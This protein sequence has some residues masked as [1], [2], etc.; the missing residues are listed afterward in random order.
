MSAGNVTLRASER[1]A[2]SDVA[3]VAE[4]A[5]GPDC[6]SAEER[7]LP[8]SASPPLGVICPQQVQS[9]AGVQLQLF[10][11]LEEVARTWKA[12][13][14]HADRTV[15]QSF[16]WLA[17][18]QRHIGA[19]RGC[20]PAIV[21]GRDGDG[22]P[23]FILQ[24]A[25]EPSGAARRLTWLGSE[26]CDYNAPLLAEQFSDRMS[27]QRF[28]RAWRDAIALLQADAR[29]RFDLIDLQKM[30]ETIGAQRNPFLDLGVQPHPSGAYLANLGKDWEA[31]YAAKRS[32]ATRKRER[33]QL[34]QLAGHGAVRFVDVEA[35]EEAARTLATLF[36]QKSRA[37][38]R[39]GV[40]D[41]FAGPGRRDF[42]SAIAAD[43][44][45]REL[46][47][48]SRLDVGASMAAINIG[49][50]F[51]GCYYLILS[52]YD[53]GEVARFGPGR[54]HLNE[55]LRHAIARGF[56]RF[57][58]TVGDEPYKRDWSDIELALF[59]HLAAISLRGYTV[60]TMTRAFRRAKR[61]IKQSPILWPAF[62]KARA[63]AALFSSRA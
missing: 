1:H 48:V 40:D 31:F 46:V 32:S 57:D 29:F 54:A 44:S 22:E 2:Q 13:E 42:F 16:D 19:R 3:V 58:F 45:L 24:L 17:A 7:A 21:L 38:A 49:L 52:S 6:V 12:F 63:A 37:F 18:W 23:L 56:D 61:L 50:K 62:S 25:V 43:S 34:K 10:G 9:G 27:T 35:G 36:E 5:S 15:F 4:P 60:M 59:D 11:N 26:L 53:D 39:M 28:A 20:V 47:H 8:L 33:R 30:P 14:A 41:P 51:R 55:L